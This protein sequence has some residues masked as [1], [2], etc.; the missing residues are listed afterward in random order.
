MFLA[1]F[2][3]RFA[4]VRFCSTNAGGDLKLLFL[5]WIGVGSVRCWSLLLVLSW[6]WGLSRDTLL[7][8]SLGNCCGNL[9]WDLWDRSEVLSVRRWSGFWSIHR[10]VRCLRLR[11][12]TFLFWA[13]MLGIPCLLLLLK[14]LLLLLIWVRFSFLR[15]WHQA[16]AWR[17]LEI[18]GCF[19][20]FLWGD[21]FF[22]LVRWF[23]VRFCW[24][25][26]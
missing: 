17:C 20:I 18:P 23:Q 5:L 24:D 13:D 12:W 14:F 25:S 2:P 1:L 10:A 22:V 15:W 11:L 4:D 16:R 3:R 9:Q 6:F 7:L 26:I 21:C 19:D 8:S